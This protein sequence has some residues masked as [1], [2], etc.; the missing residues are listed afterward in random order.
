MGAD[1]EMTPR[2]GN[3]VTTGALKSP[4][5]LATSSMSDVKSRAAGAEM[6]GTGVAGNVIVLLHQ[7]LLL[8]PLLVSMVHV[9]MEGVGIAMVDALR[10]SPSP[11]TLIV[12]WNGQL[13]LRSCAF[14][15]DLHFLED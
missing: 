15:L 6:S 11:V 12:E 4:S 13:E 8:T 2:D 5:R 10:D 3:V 7:C 9:P 14:P 1:G